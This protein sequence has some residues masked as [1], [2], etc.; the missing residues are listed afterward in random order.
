MLLFLTHAN[1]DFTRNHKSKISKIVFIL[2][3]LISLHVRLCAQKN[4]IVDA[5]LLSTHNICFGWNGKNNFIL[6]SRGVRNY[7][8]VRNS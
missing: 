7:D 6:L 3:F 8:R 2:Y 1:N 5:V 4:R